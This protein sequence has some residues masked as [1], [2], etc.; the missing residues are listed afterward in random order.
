MQTTDIDRWAREALQL[1]QDAGI[2]AASWC[3]DGNSDP[4]ERGRV[5]AMLR[6][7]DPMAFDYLPSMPNL[8]GGWADDPTPL[9]LA[10]DIT[11]DDDPSPELIDTLADTWESGVALTFESE[12]ERLL[13]AFCS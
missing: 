5:L 10:R 13:T 3:F 1:G 8:S 11:G 9:S 4:A 2:A 7:G 6:D 12:C